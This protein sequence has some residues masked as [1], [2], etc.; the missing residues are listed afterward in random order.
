LTTPSG[1]EH[2]RSLVYGQTVSADFGSR[3]ATVPDIT[4]VYVRNA[5]WVGDDGNK[6]NLTFKEYLAANAL[7]DV[8]WGYRVDNISPLT[9]V[10][11]LNLNQIVLR[12]HIAPKPM[13]MPTPGSIVLDGAVADYTIVSSA[14]PDTRTMVLTLDRPLG[15]LPGGG[16]NGERVLMTVPGGS[17]DGTYRLNITSLQ[18]DANHLFVDPAFVDLSDDGRIGQRLNRTTND[19]PGTAPLYTPYCDL[20]ADGVIT[21]VDYDACVARIGDRTPTTDP[22]GVAAAP[23]PAS[24]RI[25]PP[26]RSALADL[27]R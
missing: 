16:E 11:W 8:N 20:D 12:Y 26:A 4:H 1:G 25:R 21:Q 22:F 19:P 5:A 15:N 10:P 13:A 7:G 18:G 23:P 9:T 3:I 6:N 14:W 2:L 24:R 17:A 27:L